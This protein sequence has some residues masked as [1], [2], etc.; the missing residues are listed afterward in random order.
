[1]QLSELLTLSGV[2]VIAR[3]GDG[4]VTSLVS[5]SRRCAA[6]ACFVAV[7]GPRADG[8]AFIAQAVAGGAAAMVCE[9]SAA[10]PAGVPY[11]VV[12][13]AA[14]AVGPLAQ[15]FH[16]WPARKLVNVGVTGTKGK[17][18]VTLLTRA[19]LE[20][21]GHRPALLGTISYDTGA[22]SLEANNTTPGAVDLAAMMSDM[23]R[24]GRTHLVMEVSSHALHQGRVAGVP[25]AAAA[26]T[27]LT[28]EHLDYHGTMENYLAAKRM[29]FE[30]LPATATAVVNADDPA[31]EAMVAATRARVLRYG[32]EGRPALGA[33][34][35]TVSDCGTEFVMRCGAGRD[36][37]VSPACREGVPPSPSAAQKGFSSFTDQSHGA[38][39]AGETPATRE[40]PA[41]RE[42]VI[43]SP[44]IGKHNVRNCL[45]AAGLCFGLGVSWDVIAAVLTAGV[46]VPGRLDRVAVAA[47]FTVY[48]DYA[49]TDDALRN[50]LEAVRPVTRGRVIVLFGCGGDRDRF[51]RPRM[52]RVAEELADAVIVT[53][54]NPRTE[55]PRAII[56]EILAGFTPAGL[57]RAQVEPDRRRA[58]AL[59]LEQARPGD[60]VLLAG[61]GHET[62][63]IVGQTKHHFDD[64]E[65]VAEVVAR[66]SRP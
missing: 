53:S 32:L 38:H 62:Y 35:R 33:E 48:V 7:R 6:G 44:L 30:A 28:G 24:A 14:R 16:G 59:A 26:F 46:R 8:H 42:M 63:Q 18:T 47:P 22:A 61:K 23:V 17:T 57:A 9:D 27:N 50:V 31:C 51:K 4:P 52:A 25:Y 49:H 37:G 41:P 34:I 45:A 5:D 65:V 12:A 15:A 60:L 1:M 40:T 43:F 20:A 10:V 2:G 11:A 56:D 58:I 64:A 13:D 21:A 39:N 55:D 3:S 66:A 19:I 54:D 29:L 36:A